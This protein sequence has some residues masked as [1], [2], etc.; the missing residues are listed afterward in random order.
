MSIVCDQLWK[1]TQRIVR[2]LGEELVEQVGMKAFVGRVVTENNSKKR[3]TAPEAFN[4]FLYE[5]S[6][7]DMLKGGK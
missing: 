5:T 2:D 4:R 6:H 3:Y 7:K 1:Q